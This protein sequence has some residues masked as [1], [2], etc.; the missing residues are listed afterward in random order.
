MKTVNQIIRTTTLVLLCSL[1]SFGQDHFELLKEKKE[2][3]ISDPKDELAT[4]HIQ[5]LSHDL[6]EYN[7]HSGSRLSLDGQKLYFFVEDHSD[8]N[9]TKGQE[10][11]VSER[12]PDNKWSNAKLLHELNNQQH[13]GVHYVSHDNERLLLLAEYNRDGSSTKGVSMTTQQEDGSW[14]LPDALKIKGYRNDDVCSFYMSADEQ[15]LLLAINQKDSYGEQ[16]IYVSFKSGKKWSKPLNLGAQINS[17]GSDGAMTLSADG[18]TLYFS[19]NARAEDGYGGYDIY[20]SER[21]D[22]SWTNWSTPK[23]LGFP[24]NTPH[25]ELYFTFS[26]NDEFSYLSRHFVENDTIH[27]SDIIAI[28]KQVKSP[29]SF[30]IVN[31]YDAETNEEI[32]A[33]VS[34]LND[35]SK[36]KVTFTSHENHLIEKNKSYSLLVSAPGYIANEQQLVVLSENDTTEIPISLNPKREGTKW[37]IE[38]IFFAFDDSKLLDTSIPALNDL[39]HIMTRESDLIV[40]ISGHTDS[41]GNDSYNL[42]LSDSRSEAVVNYLVDHGISSARLKHKGYGE[43]MLI[44][45]CTNGEICSE[46]LHQQNRRVELKIIGFENQLL[47]N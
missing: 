34:L 43:T 38:N 27:H 8:Q 13:N 37:E 33:S 19:S 17:V 2:L 32:K 44:N 3:S 22:D 4:Y 10:I 9:K 45:N 35:E 26:P 16:D 24:Y 23:N 46:E 25:D 7:I 47:L 30:L 18:K 28:K 14:S 40:E 6:N 36:S 1:I 39:I 41:R 15:S 42:K 11:A 20:K 12:L 5:N 21:L 31:A 29:T